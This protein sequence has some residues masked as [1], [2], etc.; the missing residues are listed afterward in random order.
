M[1]Y[2]SLKELTKEM[3]TGDSELQAA[4]LKASF[5]DNSDQLGAIITAISRVAEVKGKE[6]ISEDL[7]A[8]PNPRIDAFFKIIDALGMRLTVEVKDQAG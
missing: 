5:E 6:Y 8:N 3:L 7:C 4:Y 2:K 1:E